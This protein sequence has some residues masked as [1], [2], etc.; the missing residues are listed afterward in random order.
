MEKNLNKQDHSRSSGV[1]CPSTSQSRSR[2]CCSYQPVNISRSPSSSGPGP[3]NVRLRNLFFHKCGLT[4]GD[5][6]VIF[7]LLGVVAFGCGYYFTRALP[8][9]IHQVARW[10]EFFRQKILNIDPQQHSFIFYLIC[11]Y[12]LKYSFSPFF[13]LFTICT[14]LQIQHSLNLS[15]ISEIIKRCGRQLNF[16]RQKRNL[17]NTDICWVLCYFPSEVNRNK[18]IFLVFLVVHTHGNAIR[19]L[20]K[21]E[22]T[23]SKADALERSSTLPPAIFNKDFSAA[24]WLAESMERSGPDQL[25]MSSSLKIW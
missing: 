8:Y 11:F 21:S 16:S 17:N 15:L 3:R 10:F 9:K 1:S 12:S 25:E 14:Y 24:K 20:K 6:T 5:C 18:I 22:A 13:T 7:L 4:R 19:E 2:S 23:T